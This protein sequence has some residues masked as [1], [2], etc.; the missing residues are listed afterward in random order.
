MCDG[1]GRS[2]VEQHSADYRTLAVFGSVPDAER[3]RGLLE[4]DGIVAAVQ[5]A[6]EAAA[7]RAGA[8]KLLVPARDLDRA[9]RLLTP[10]P[11]MGDAGEADPDQRPEADPTWTIGW[12]ALLAAAL[13]ALVAALAL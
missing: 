3:A 6:R 2:Q 10:A 12:L 9:R 7:V 5:D 13:V 1:E 11:G 4:S 8:V